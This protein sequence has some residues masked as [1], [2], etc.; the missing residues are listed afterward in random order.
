MN[1]ILISVFAFL[2]IF[3]FTGLLSVCMR[4]KSVED[5]LLASRKVSLSFVGLSGAASTTDSLVLSC[6]AS[7]SR[8][9]AP[10]YKESYLVLK[11]STIGVTAGALALALFG[12]QSIFGIWSG[13]CYVSHRK[14]KLEKI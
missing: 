2:S 5:Y 4:Q 7:I 12:G 6:T 3:L 11:I 13:T 14:K 8:D 10:K 1:L 9:I